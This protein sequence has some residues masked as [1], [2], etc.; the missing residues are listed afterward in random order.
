[1]SFRMLCFTALALAAAEPAFSQA[2][3][4]VGALPDA[5]AVRYARFLTAMH[6]PSL[7]EFVQAK[8]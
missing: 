1:M 2:Y 3:F 8:A 7:Y 4:P 5:A 6:E